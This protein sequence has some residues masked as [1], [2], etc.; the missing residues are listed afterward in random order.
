MNGLWQS[1]S[2]RSGRLVAGLGFL[3]L[4][5]M[6]MGQLSAFPAAK[7]KTAGEIM[8]ADSDNLLP[9]SK[10]ETFD[11]LDSYLAHLEKLGT[12]DIPYYLLQPDGRFEL[13]T[14]FF[15]NQTGQRMFTREELMLKYGFDK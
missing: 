11:D 14:P 5:S 8:A 15:S 9:F 12:I 3:V 1:W 2:E 10:G 6:M 4:S 13:M 7:T